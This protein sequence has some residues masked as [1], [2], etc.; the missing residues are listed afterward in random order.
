VHRDGGRTVAVDFV[1]VP[2][3]VLAR[4]VPLSTSCGDVAVTVSYGGAIYASI[5]AAGRT[6]VVP[7]VTGM[8]YRTGEHTFVVD[9]A[10]PL[11]PGFV[12]R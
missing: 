12:L 9:P 2:S 8:A 11:V 7:K 10:D 6:A 5:D 3:Y 4:D 1:N